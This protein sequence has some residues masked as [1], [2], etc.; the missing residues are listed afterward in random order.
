M[1]ISTFL[2]KLKRSR[3]GY[4]TF[5]DDLPAKFLQILVRIVLDGHY[6]VLHAHGFSVLIH[7]G[8]LRF[9][10]RADAPDSSIVHGV[11]QPF[12][13]FIRKDHRT[14]RRVQVSLVA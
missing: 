12:A 11:I 1:R 8:H 7:H 10:I 2:G 4:S 5:R 9:A 13:D 14:G 3:M 6:N